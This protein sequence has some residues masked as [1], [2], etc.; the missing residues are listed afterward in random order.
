LYGLFMAFLLG[1][2]RA[3]SAS[4]KLRKA[5]PDVKVLGDGRVRSQ[6]SLGG[7]VKRSLAMVFL[8]L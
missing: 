3:A 5:K 2:A 1:S 4:V 6:L 8:R 7:S